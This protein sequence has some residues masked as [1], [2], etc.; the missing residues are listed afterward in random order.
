VLCVLLA[1]HALVSLDWLAILCLLE[2]RADAVLC[3]L[4]AVLALVSLD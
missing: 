1:V 4:L 3:V 2:L